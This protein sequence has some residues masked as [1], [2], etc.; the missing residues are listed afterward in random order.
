MKTVISHFYNEAYLLPW[1]LNHHKQFFDH[2]IMINYN[3]NDSSVD[4][5]RSICPSWEII[6]TRNKC[7]EAQKVDDEI[8]D[9]ENNIP[10][11]RIV[12]NTTEFLI[13]KY[14][15]LNNSL[16][17]SDIYVPSFT[18]ID[19]LDNNGIDSTIPL[20]DQKYHGA[21]YDPRHP[22]DYIPRARRLSNF[23]V[24]HSVGRHY[25]KRWKFLSKDFII[26]WYGYSPFNEFLIQRKIQIQNNIPESDK[27]RGYGWQHIITEQQIIDNIYKLQMHRKDLSEM[28]K[29]LTNV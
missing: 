16:S 20:I 14:S 25:K 1:W 10:D 3:S 27:K 21:Y 7:F 18:M 4:I 22:K 15:N 12:L 29:N 28:I 6:N 13:G 17:M 23:R 11:W 19:S 9:I 24:K 2:G 5:I 26:L 8:Y